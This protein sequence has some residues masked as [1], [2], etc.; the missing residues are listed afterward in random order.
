M[1]SKET[2]VKPADSKGVLDKIKLYFPPAFIVSFVFNLFYG[3]FYYR[4]FA[5]S[6]L[7]DTVSYFAA[8]DNILQGKTDFL[9][10][11][12]Y[13]LFLDFCRKVN[14]DHV[15]EFAVAIQF[16]VFYISM[17]FFYKLMSRFTSNPAFLATATI[18][19]GCMSPVIGYN[20][21][22][23]TE[24]FS[25]SGL[26]IFAYLLV[27]FVEKRKYGYYTACILGTFFM[28]MLRP[29]AVYL[30]IVVAVAAIPSVIALIRK[31]R[32]VKLHEILVPVASFVLCIAALLGY[33]GKNKK[34]YGFFGISYV[35]EMNRFYDVVQAD[36]WSDNQDSMVVNCIA[37]NIGTGSSPLGAAIETEINFRNFKTEPDRIPEFS[38][39]AIKAHP[40][41]YY[42]YLAKKVLRMG[43]TNTEYFL[44]N[45]SFYFKEG[46]DKSTL[47]IGD[48]LDFNVNFVYFVFLLSAIGIIAYGIRKKDVLWS[49]L[50]ITLIIGGQLGVNV[51]AG[52]AEFHRLNAPCYPFAIMLALIW[53]GLAFD[54]LIEKK[55]G[56]EGS[57]SCDQ[58]RK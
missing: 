18:F 33:M 22:L 8:I 9:R 30:Y 12:V 36:I 21:L 34:E 40:D 47:W 20:Y 53:A 49:M 50:L 6:D 52:P 55:S 38:R 11:P 14:P 54:K 17:W 16:V 27:L 4:Q 46:A 56:E 29:S 10:T 5:A 31:K 45:D 51:L 37:E 19:Y 1:S 58:T 48:L 24:S 42:Y 41:K 2:S 3:I 57:S 7:Y 28:T 35:S 32:T 25:I 13:P 26:V 23:L 43:E 15:K 44:T 39:S